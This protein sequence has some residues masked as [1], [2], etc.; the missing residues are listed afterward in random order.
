MGCANH[1]KNWGLAFHN[2][3]S[4]TER[5]PAIW[6]LNPGMHNWSVPL[7]PHVEQENLFKQINPVQ[8]WDGAANLAAAAARIPLLAIQMASLGPFLVSKNPVHPVLAITA[9]LAF[10]GAS[11][12]WFFGA[13]LSLGLFLM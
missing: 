1:L 9:W 7:L 13:L 2:H 6:S 4:A 12:L 3:L 5:F 11:G 10:T 8:D